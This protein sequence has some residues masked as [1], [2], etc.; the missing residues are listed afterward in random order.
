MKAILPF[1]FSVRLKE[2]GNKFIGSN[3]SENTIQ[4]EEFLTK[5]SLEDFKVDSSC[6]ND[7]LDLLGVC[8][9]LP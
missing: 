5:F 3:R 2:I 8:K 7:C 9:K 4:Q 1:A 6:P